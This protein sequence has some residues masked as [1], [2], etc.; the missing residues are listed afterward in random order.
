M[1]RVDLSRA[2]ALLLASIL[3]ASAASAQPVVEETIDLEFDR[4]E[5]WAMKFFAGVTLPV[6]A[7]MD[8]PLPPGAFAIEFEAITIPSLSPS[9]RK[10][11]FDGIK[12]EDL[13]KLPALGR[14]RLVVGLPGGLHAMAGWVPPLEISGVKG[15]LLS[16]E[17]GREIPLFRD[18]SASVRAFA[19]DGKIEGAFTC[20]DE[21][22]EFPPASPGNPFACEEL[23]EDEYSIQVMGGEIQVG[24]AIDRLGG[25]WIHAGAAAAAMDAEFQV[26]ALRS[27][28]L[29]RTLLRSDG[30]IVTYN[31]GAR[32]ALASG[33]TVGGEVV[34]SPLSVDRNDGRGEVNDPMLN[35]HFVVG[36]RPAS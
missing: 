17:I 29:D 23:S 14:G 3:V 24:R 15:N 20:W 35:F 34:Y 6:A 12:E 22:L 30:T 36:I 10:V 32:W 5:S 28:F 2:V 19:Q 25:P 8:R 13:N 26:S 1:R 4:P 16:A 7:A 27:G 18:W 31:A 21:V 33:I 11:G 9:Q